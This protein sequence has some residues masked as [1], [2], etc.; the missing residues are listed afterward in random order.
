MITGNERKNLR[1]KKSAILV[2]MALCLSALVLI[3]ATSYF[4]GIKDHVITADSAVVLSLGQT[5]TESL[6][7]NEES[8]TVYRITAVVNT[9]S[10]AQNVNATLKIAFENLS[11]ELTLNN[12]TFELCDEEENRIGQNITTGASTLAESGISETATYYVKIYLTP[13]ENGEKY[14]ANELKQIGGTMT[15]S[16]TSLNGG[17]ENE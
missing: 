17:N 2:G 10:N 16:F 11:E 3:F 13:K 12:I 15:I 14:T 8:A 5:S 7:L 6:T 1:H 9:S 4:D